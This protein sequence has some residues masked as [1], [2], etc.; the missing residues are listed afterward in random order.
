LIYITVFSLVLKEDRTAYGHKERSAL[1]STPRSLDPTSRTTDLPAASSLQPS[2]LFNSSSPLSSSL[3]PFGYPAG[4]PSPYI[5]WP[6]LVSLRHSQ[7]IKTG[8]LHSQPTAN[9]PFPSPPARRSSSTSPP[10]RNPTNSVAP[11]II[12]SR[13]VNHSRISSRA[14]GSL[15]CLSRCPGLTQ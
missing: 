1:R 9:S 14:S 8:L 13:Y 12:Y 7:D 2:S 11:Q 5:N 10:C 3:L 15:Y 4:P 6:D